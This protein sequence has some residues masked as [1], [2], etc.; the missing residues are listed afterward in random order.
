MT[1][2]KPPQKPTNLREYDCDIVIGEQTFTKLEISPDYEI[3]N[4]EFEEGL[5]EKGIRLTKKELAKVLINDNL[6]CELVEQ[7][8]GK[9]EQE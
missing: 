4:E 7:L 9:S 3:K 2:K 8:D 6:I 1:V 5:K